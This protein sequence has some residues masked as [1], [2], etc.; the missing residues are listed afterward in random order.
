MLLNSEFH[1][2]TF[3]MKFCAIMKIYNFNTDI[4]KWYINNINRHKIILIRYQNRNKT[5]SYVFVFQLKMIVLK[6]EM[7]SLPNGHFHP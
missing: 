4:Q 5:T 7:F 1:A 3:T 2:F 6:S